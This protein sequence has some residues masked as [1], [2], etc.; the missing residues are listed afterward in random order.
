MVLSTRD[1]VHSN[2]WS[3][4]DSTCGSELRMR[5]AKAPSSEVVAGGPAVGLE[6]VAAERSSCGG[7]RESE[8]KR[9]KKILCSGENTS[10]VSRSPSILKNE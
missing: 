9:F 7:G 2:C 8:V 1:W 3:V 5:L 4:S 10:E 6:V